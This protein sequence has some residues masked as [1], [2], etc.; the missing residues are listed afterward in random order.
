M[1]NAT[2][3]SPR[4]AANSAKRRCWPTRLRTGPGEV[5]EVLF[6]EDG[7][8]AAGELAPE[9]LVGPGDGDGEANRRRVEE[10]K[11]DGSRRDEL[12]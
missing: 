1:F 4:I 3:R 11:R 9:A 2:L 7:Q 5:V 12:N 6:C 8:F 10:N